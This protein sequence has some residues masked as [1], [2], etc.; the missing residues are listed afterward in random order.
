MKEYVVLGGLALFIYWLNMKNS[1]YRSKYN[2][3]EQYNKLNNPRKMHNRPRRF[4]KN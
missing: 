3:N 1:P 4:R 2:R